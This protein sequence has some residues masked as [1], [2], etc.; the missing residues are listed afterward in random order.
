MRRRGF[1]LI[2]LLVV[3]A[4]IAILAAIL[5]PVLASAKERAR[6][7]MC[8]SN[9]RQLAS[10]LREYSDDHNGVMPSGSA[11]QSGQ[12]SGKY[13]EWTGSPDC[14]R[15]D[16]DLS[17]GQL[18]RY[19]RNKGIYRCPSDGQVAAVGITNPV[20]N[21]RD[22]PLSYSLNQDLC[23]IYG[24]SVVWKRALKLDAETAGRAGR[25]LLLIHEARKNIKRSA[26]FFRAFQNVSD[27]RTIH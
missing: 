26:A 20:A 5:F 12:A 13:V 16:V 2:E 27:V 9:L 4:I 10:A 25:C 6:Q 18:W 1:T 24:G 15:S 21:P 19:V 14:L 23:S 22:Y 8:I 3:I 7:A 11:R 17:K